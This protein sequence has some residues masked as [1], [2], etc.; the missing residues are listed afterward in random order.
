MHLTNHNS[1]KKEISMSNIKI[2]LLI[3]LIC[4]ICIGSVSAS[5]FCGRFNSLTIEEQKHNLLN[6][7]DRSLI[8]SLEHKKFISML[9]RKERIDN[10]MALPHM[11]Q[12]IVKACKDGNNFSAGSLIGEEIAVHKMYYLM[13]K[14]K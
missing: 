9:S 7:I 3:V 10:D 4:F 11:H 1:T 13:F 14:V 2:S 8:D 12:D 5:D 6:M